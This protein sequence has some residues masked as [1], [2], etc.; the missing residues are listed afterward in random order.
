VPYYWA[1]L[2]IFPLYG[3]IRTL[4]EG[5]M[6]GFSLFVPGVIGGISVVTGLFIKAWWARFLIIIG[7]SI[8]F[9]V[10]IVIYGLSA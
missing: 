10:G 5:D 8:W 1:L 6:A 9:L 7:M 4:F 3:L 2:H